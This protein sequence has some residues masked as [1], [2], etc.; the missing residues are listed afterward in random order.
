MTNV[1]T[2]TELKIFQA[3]V[4]KALTRCV[5]EVRDLYL[6]LG[7]SYSSLDPYGSAYHLQGS[8]FC[9]KWAVPDPSIV[10]TLTQQCY[11]DW[12]AHEEYL[13]NF[14]VVKNIYASEH[15]WLHFKARDLLHSWLKGFRPDRSNIEFTP[16]TTFLKT[17][18]TSVFRK[19]SDLKHWTV[20]FDA[21]DDALDLICATS[22]LWHCALMHLSRMD[23]VDFIP[24][25]RNDVRELIAKHVLTVVD[26]ARAATVYKNNEKRRFINIE[27]TFNMLLQRTVASSLRKILRA[28]SN[29]LETGQDDHKRLISDLSYA[30]VD[31]SN[32]SD[33]VHLDW[34]RWLLPDKVFNYLY[35]YR[36]YYTII[37]RDGIDHYFVNKKLSAMGNGFTFEVMTMLLLAYSRVL[38]GSSRVYGDDVI[39]RGTM[40]KT[41][42]NSLRECSW[43]INDK[44][45]FIEG[46]FRES[47]GAFFT[48]SYGYIESYDFRYAESPEEAIILVNKLRRMLHHGK[49]F[50]SCY[51]HIIKCT[52][53]LLK[54]PCV[55][56]HVP[57]KWVET[58][59]YLRAKKSDKRSIA[60]WKKRKRLITLAESMWQKKVVS[61]NQG[62]FFKAASFTLGL[63][64]SCVFTFY[65]YMY[66]GRVT[67]DV[68][69]GKGKWRQSEILLFDD[70]SYCLVSSVS[71][72]RSGIYDRS[73]FSLDYRRQIFVGGS[74]HY[75][76]CVHP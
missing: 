11:D 62:V 30:T 50:K 72:I 13:W 14:D 15:K 55:Y 49:A 43:Q 46:N 54:G 69:R 66:T 65:T 68:L 2:H 45:T 20:T 63:D 24:E 44:K 7:P 26:G 12:I 21:F 75:V 10:R 19:L 32:A 16:G 4:N 70:G 35:R 1:V 60:L 74:P 64:I 40:A 67:D 41:F 53:A 52:P 48:K 6:P 42:C 23:T 57:N 9:G 33:S 5:D 37:N 8:R 51:D 47:C 39:I 38:D 71:K 36:S 61:L 27:P 3:E 31:F 28:E 29:D 73:R 25:N 22:S 76:A 17:S 59:S 58:T 34:V 56:D 18:G